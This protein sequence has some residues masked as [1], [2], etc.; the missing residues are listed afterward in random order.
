MEN[1]TQRILVN[2]LP[3]SGTHLLTRS[4]ELFGFKEYF[5]HRSFNAKIAEKAG[6]G[7]PKLLNYRQAKLSRKRQLEDTHQ[8]IPIG[9]LS[10]YFV[11][12]ATAQHWFSRYPKNHY[13]H[14]HVPYSLELAEILTELRYRHVLIMRD[15]RAVIVSQLAHILQTNDKTGMG[16]HFLHQDFVALDKQQQLDFMLKGG[17][18]KQAGLLVQDFRTV[19]DSML[20]WHKLPGCLLVKYESLVG[21][22][23]GGSTDTQRV[24]VAQIAEHLGQSL[25]KDNQIEQIYS[26]KSRTFRSGKISSWQDDLTPEQIEQVNGYCEPLR[27]AAGYEA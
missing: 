1:T 13:V 14:G 4:V 9:A 5:T 7:I 18:A 22:Q 10:P 17:H 12:R 25:P 20:A 19:Y 3:K 26:A 11:N 15:P 24:T 8:P 23:G 21:E 27:E 16:M 6:F 2:S